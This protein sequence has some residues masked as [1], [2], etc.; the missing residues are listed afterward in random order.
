MSRRW[1][2][3]FIIQILVMAGFVWIPTVHAESI[4]E[5][6][7]RANHHYVNAEFSQAA[8]AYL[9][10]LE[11]G[12]SGE[13]YYN[14][15]NA[16]VKEGRNGPALWAYLKAKRYM[17]NDSDLASNLRY[18]QSELSRSRAQS[19]RPH[20]LVNQAYRLWPGSA[21]G[22]AWMVWL[23]GVLILV[24]FSVCKWYSILSGFNWVPFISGI[25]F[26]V[27]VFGLAGRTWWE[28]Q[29][30]A[31]VTSGSVEAKFAPSAEGTAHFGL[32]EGT[33]VRLMSRAQGGW[34]QVS[35]RDGLSGWVREQDVRAL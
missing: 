30:L 28:S 6:W 24:I 27:G 33:R 8:E 32:A 9:E 17:P 29:P 22:L 23:S 21:T 25:L 18:V 26:L 11:S 13:L 31:V 5:Q 16:W 35:R 34:I 2:P 20:W 4:D 15:G 12:E 7:D 19:V 1:W 10:L 3:E 14:L